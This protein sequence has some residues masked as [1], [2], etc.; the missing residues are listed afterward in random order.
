[1]RELQQRDRDDQPQLEGL[2][3][4]PGGAYR[5]SGSGNVLRGQHR[6]RSGGW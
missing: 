5:S 4:E 1:M 2:Q 3:L 6:I